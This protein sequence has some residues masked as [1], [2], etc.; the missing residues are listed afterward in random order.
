MYHRLAPRYDESWRLGLWE[1]LGLDEL[2]QAG[3][4]DGISTFLIELAWS[5]TW[6]H[7]KEVVFASQRRVLTRHQTFPS[8][9]LDFKEVEASP[10]SLPDPAYAVVL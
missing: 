4:N 3:L 6:G 5:A 8:L 10:C 9:T 7:S 1:V 2:M